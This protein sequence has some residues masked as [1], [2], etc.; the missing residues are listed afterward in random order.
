MASSERIAAVLEEEVKPL[1]RGVS[2]ALAFLA[3]LAGCV[4]LARVPVEGVRYVGALV[5]GATLL[6]LFGVSALYHCPNWSPTTG[7]YIQ[8]C[9][10]AAISLVIAGSFTPLATLDIPGWGGPSLVVMWAAALTGAGFALSGRSGPRGLRSLLYVLLGSMALPVVSRLPAV[11]GPARVGALL[12][13]GVF[14]AVGAAVYARRWPDPV[15]T[16]FGFHEIFHL[17]V[18]AAAGVE[19]AVVYDVLGGR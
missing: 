2:H 13:V 19:F 11:I 1:L 6:V 7:Q 17:L 15:P 4:L 5:F 8:R 14:Y 18:I 16:V 3:A 10:H 9:D 12:L